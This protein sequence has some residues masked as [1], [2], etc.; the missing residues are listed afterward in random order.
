MFCTNPAS[1][2]ASIASSKRCCKQALLQ[3]SVASSKRCCKQALL[4]AS[5]AASKHCC[6]Q[7]LLQASIAAS[8]RCCKQALLQASVAARKRCWYDT[9]FITVQP[10]LGRCCQAE[11]ALLGWWLWRN[12]DDRM[13]S[14]FS[15]SA[16]MGLQHAV[17][18]SA[19]ENL[20]EALC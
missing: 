17:Y 6:K 18:M 13:P 7:A 16:N 4:Q 14:R 19:G 9:S 11:T 10:S 1:A 5:A 12:E 15:A 8:K 2:A 20:K 3:A